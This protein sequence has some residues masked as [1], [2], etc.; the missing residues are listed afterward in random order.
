MSTV[1]QSVSN[2]TFTAAASISFTLSATS[3]GN[4]LVIELQCGT[5]ATAYT[6]ATISDNGAGNTWAGAVVNAV[7]QRL[8][9]IARCLSVSA[10]VTSVTLTP[11]GGT[12]GIFG[13]A[14]IQEVSGSGTWA[15]DQHGTAGFSAG[16]VTAT[17]SGA[18]AGTTDFVAG[19]VS[20][21]NSSTSVGIT[22]PPTGF[23]SAAVQQND[24]VSTGG[25]CCYR[26]NSTAVTD[27]A[28][29]SSANT[30]AGDPAVIASFTAAGGGGTFP[31]VPSPILL[32]NQRSNPILGM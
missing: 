21:G 22:D 18:D 23:T 14:A 5:G 25:E 27:S 4:L 31:P 29:W 12:G 20:T 13:C 15:D 10:G 11:T 19:C 26:I 17:C 9:L 1:V 24:F 16:S 2:T 30:T 28:T 8:C 3:A 32:M 6:G 7:N